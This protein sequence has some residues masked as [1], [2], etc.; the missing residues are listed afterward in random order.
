MNKFLTFAMLLALSLT[1]YAQDGAQ[2]PLHVSDSFLTVRSL[3]VS[4][5]ISATNLSIVD[6]TLTTNPAG[7]VFTNLYGTRVVVTASAYTNVNMFRTV[8]LY[9]L[10]DG[11]APF[12][13]L[14]D[15]T[16]QI[17]ASVPFANVSVSIAGGSGANVATSFVLS[18]VYD[19]DYPS[20]AAGDD[21]IFVV[22]PNGATTV[23]VATNLPIWRW[24]GAQGLTVK[25][26]T[27]GDTDASSQVV[28]KALKLNAWRPK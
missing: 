7:L 24:P 21:F 1:T 16:N 26:I 11:A 27:A 20:T 17:S 13:Q 28:I 12:R 22:T 3:V 18:P 14:L 8:P 9:S 2:E 6:G 4:N 23:T 25:S 5:T 19:G 10:R 15:S